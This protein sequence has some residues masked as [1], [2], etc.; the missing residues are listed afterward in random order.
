L[1]RGEVR[2]ESEMLDWNVMQADGFVPA[3]WHEHFKEN[4]MLDW[5]MM[6]ERLAEREREVKAQMLVHEALATQEPHQPI[7]G[8]LLVWA[9]VRLLNAGQRIEAR[10]NLYSGGSPAPLRGILQVPL[11]GNYLVSGSTNGSP[12][13]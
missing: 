8:R 10:S 5:Y 12:C 9:G 4:A 2:K 6:Q 1:S 7:S 11:A 3:V 13:D